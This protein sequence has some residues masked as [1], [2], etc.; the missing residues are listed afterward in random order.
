MSFRLLT[1]ISRFLSEPS[2]LQIRYYAA[3][4]GTRERKAKKKVKKE[5]VETPKFIPH[6]ERNKEKF[7]ALR[8][9]LK[10]DDSWKQPPPSD[11]VY[12]VRYYQRPAMSLVEA[13][14]NHRETHHPDMYNEPGASLLVRIELNMQGEKATRFVDDFTRIVPIPFKFEHGEERPI[15]AFAKTGS[16]Q[17]EALNAGAQLAGGVDLIKQ[18]QNGA[19]SLQNFK[20]VIAH[21]DILP[22]LV[23]LRGLMKRR[24]PNPKMGTLDVDLGAVAERFVN[25]ISYTAK[26]DEYEKDF[27]LIE[28]VIG[29]LDMDVEHLE[30]NFG[31][32]VKDVYSMRPKR[33]GDFI[34][35]CLLVSPPSSE[36][37]KV[38]YRGYVEEAP[39]KVVDQE[40]EEEKGERVAL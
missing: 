22:E 30:G 32:L 33:Q 19:V 28:T 12:H 31:A 24:F 3:R 2:H 10:Y 18:V 25:G 17:K 36:K 20:F 8:P 38:E 1:S 27:G 6:N 40:E 4:K 13:I 7:L 14:K 16:A 23:A 11:D 39:R 34:S 21:P 15:I 26:K 35:R 5:V 37:F 9:K 29:S